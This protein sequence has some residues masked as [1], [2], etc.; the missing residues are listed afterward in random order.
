M[1]NVI[2]FWGTSI[3]W[4]SSWAPENMQYCSGLGC[5]YIRW[6]I[7]SCKN[8]PQIRKS[9]HRHHYHLLVWMRNAR[10]TPVVKMP[11]ARYKK[12]WE[13]QICNFFRALWEGSQIVN[14]RRA[15]REIHSRN[16]T[17]LAIRVILNYATSEKM[18][19]IRISLLTVCSDKIKHSFSP[20]FLSDC[21][22]Y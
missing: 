20:Y 1:L 4:I 2:S 5:K 19:N 12:V 21:S 22:L 3:T 15:A 13:S 10:L 18:G 14:A 9:R 7:Y 11:I 6:L 8:I 16:A 17:V